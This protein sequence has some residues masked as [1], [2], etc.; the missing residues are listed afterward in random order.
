[1]VDARLPSGERVNVVLPPLSIDG[2]QLTIRRFPRPF[3]MDEFITRGTLSPAIVE[4]LSMCV[5]A[6]LNIIISGGTGSGK[7]TMLN[8][9]SASLGD[10]ERIVTIEDAAELQLTQEHVIRLESRPPNIEGSGAV[11]IRDLVRN[12]LRMR[13]DRIIV[14]EVRGGETLDMLQAMNT[15]HDGSLATVHA[16]SVIEAAMRLETLASMSE[17][18]IPFEAL[19]DQI[20]S[21]I[22]IVVQLDRGADGVRRVTAIGAVSSSHREPFELTDVCSFVT[23]RNDPVRG[24]EGHWVYSQL[25]ANIAERMRL[26]NLALAD[27]VWNR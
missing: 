11:S 10:H 23:T 20:N 4:L 15:G 1:M 18:Q 27:P 24:V 5:Q 8:T 26:R 13:P 14:G 9:L 7:T 6:R 12:A 17:L 21:A 19:R 22:D 25:P 2:P 16:N 3:T